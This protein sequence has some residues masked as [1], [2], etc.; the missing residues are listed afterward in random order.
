MQSMAFQK[1]LERER[2][3][4]KE[5]RRES[6]QASL[7]VASNLVDINMTNQ[8][9]DSLQSRGNRV[10]SS[11]CLGT[12]VCVEYMICVKNE[13]WDCAGRPTDIYKTSASRV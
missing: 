3:R 2:E 7:K 1:Q 8:N 6:G 5:R 12:T 13:T 4:E 10:G 9:L 11:C